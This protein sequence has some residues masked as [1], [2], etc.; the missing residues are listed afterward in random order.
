MIH[1]HDQANLLQEHDYIIIIIY[2]QHMYEL[3][4]SFGDVVDK[5]SDIHKS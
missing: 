2:N 4:L 1:C 5:I 3:N